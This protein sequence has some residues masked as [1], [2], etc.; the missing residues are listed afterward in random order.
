MLKVL[1]MEITEIR[2]WRRS[3]LLALGGALGAAAGV[4][5]T[6]LIIHYLKKRE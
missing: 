2:G 6:A 5:I 4:L 1:R 3:A